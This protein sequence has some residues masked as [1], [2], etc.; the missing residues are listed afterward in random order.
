[1]CSNGCWV[2]PDSWPSTLPRCSAAA[3]GVLL[4][5][6]TQVT[7]GA[8]GAVFGLMGAIVVVQRAAG[9]DVWRSPLVPVL[10][11]NLLLT[12]AVPQ[13]SIGGHLG[14]LL[15]GL[16]IGVLMVESVRRR[17]AAWTAVGITVALS[18]G[19]VAASIWA[20]A[21]WQDPLF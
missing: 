6:P 5:D 14:G 4:L 16:A 11:V 1:M 19:L 3:F 18:V 10:G 20:A 2:V 7:V 9:F 13:I 17:L 15:T 21:Q 12:F 8:S